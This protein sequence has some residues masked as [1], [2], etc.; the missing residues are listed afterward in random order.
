MHAALQAVGED[1]GVLEVRGHAATVTFQFVRAP[2]GLLQ[3][4]LERSHLLTRTHAR[5]HTHAHAVFVCTFRRLIS[6]RR[7]AAS[8]GV[9]PHLGIE[10][11]PTLSL[12]FQ[13]F[14]GLLES[15]ADEF[16]LRL[17]ALQLHGQL[18]VCVGRGRVMG[19]DAR[20][21]L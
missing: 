7:S 15:S 14:L 8:T 4:A 16:H 13:F 6:R 19:R 2:S 17:A 11:L 18:A 9:P 21:Y 20:C 12:G 5:A 3:L 10:L 1:P